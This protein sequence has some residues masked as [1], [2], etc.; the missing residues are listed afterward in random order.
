MCILSPLVKPLAKALLHYAPS[1]ACSGRLAKVNRLW[2]LI[3]RRDFVKKTGRLLWCRGL[4]LLAQ[5]VE[6]PGEQ[7]D[8]LLLAKYGAIQFVDQIL[9]IADFDF[10]FGGA[11]FH[12]G[13]LIF[14]CASRAEFPWAVAEGY[15]RV[16]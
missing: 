5:R 13:F 2:G 1:I 12:G 9:G 3:M 7:V 6:F 14:R 10:E 4:Y 15:R 11:G 16:A 8:L